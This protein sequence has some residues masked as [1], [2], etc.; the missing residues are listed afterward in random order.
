M[1]NLEEFVLT[2][3]DKEVISK[4]KELQS[5]NYSKEGVLDKIP[6]ENYDISFRLYKTSE[7]IV[8]LEFLTFTNNRRFFEPIGYYQSDNIFL[9]NAFKNDYM[10]LKAKGLINH[11]VSFLTLEEN[12]VIG[13]FSTHTVDIAIKMIKDFEKDGR[14]LNKLE[15]Y[16]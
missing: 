1:K 6:I 5:P 15:N 4:A 11:Q 8:N 10:N 16:E 7:D 2:L 3:F 9:L 12:A 13:A 14:P